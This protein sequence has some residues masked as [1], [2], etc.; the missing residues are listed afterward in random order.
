MKKRWKIILIILV[1]LLG[2]FA[3]YHIKN[4]YYSSNMD[5]PVSNYEYTTKSALCSAVNISGVQIKI[6]E[7]TLN[8]KSECKI[9]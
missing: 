9:V 8:T 1:L 7:A 5:L 6:L 4:R 3:I 2:I